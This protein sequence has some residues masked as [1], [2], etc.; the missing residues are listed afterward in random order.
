MERQ[1]A[2][3]RVFIEKM[4]ALHEKFTT[5]KYRFFPTNDPAIWERTGSIDG[6]GKQ[7]QQDE[8]WEQV[9]RAGEKHG[10]QRMTR[11]GP[12]TA[13][14][15]RDLTQSRGGGMQDRS[16]GE[17]RPPSRQARMNEFWK[18]VQ[19]DGPR[20][21]GEG[22]GEQGEQGVGDGIRGCAGT[23][24]PPECL[25]QLTEEQCRVSTYVFGNRT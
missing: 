9:C 15:R 3:A 12:L 16:T 25:V 11:T 13:V 14:D 19:G 2:H 10:N 7:R 17:S 20:V 21:E 18:G 8:G 22:W 6:Q 23:A 4:K 1:T 5:Y 24:T